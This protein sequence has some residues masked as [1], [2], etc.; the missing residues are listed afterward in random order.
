MFQRG[1]ENLETLQ[2]LGADGVLVEPSEDPGLKGAFAG[3]AGVVMGGGQSRPTLGVNLVAS[4]RLQMLVS[5]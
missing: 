5:S 3:P 4:V 1:L 2:G